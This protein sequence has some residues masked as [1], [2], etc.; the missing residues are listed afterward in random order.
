MGGRSPEGEGDDDGGDG[1]DDDPPPLAEPDPDP[2]LRCDTTTKGHINLGIQKSNLRLRLL[3]LLREKFLS[4][5]TK[6]KDCVKMYC[7]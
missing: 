6:F 2:L 4:L 3:I 1:D 7:N 5:V